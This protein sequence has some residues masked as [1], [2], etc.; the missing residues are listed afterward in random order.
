[1]FIRPERTSILIHQSS[2]GRIPGLDRRVSSHRKEIVMNTATEIM[3]ANKG[4]LKS[5]YAVRALFSAFWVGLAFTVGKSQPA[6]GIAL[7]V[8]YPTWDGLANYFDAK[9]S[10]GLRSNPTQ[11]INLIVSAVVTLAVAVAVTRDF[12]AVVGV[13]GLWAVFAGIL[14]LSTAVRRWRSASAQWPMILSGAQS[15]L[16]GA[17]FIKRAADASL[18]LSVADIAPYAAFGAI[19]FAISAVALVLSRRP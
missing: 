6:A 4:W 5:Y 3:G 17:F 15:S 11:L 12:H 16:A 9:R 18:S 10:G 2:R 1:L 19:Y 13:I 14:Q 7:V 8:A